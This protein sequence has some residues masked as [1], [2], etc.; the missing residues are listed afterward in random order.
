MKPI[1]YNKF[2]W[3]D[4]EETDTVSASSIL[5]LLPDA[6]VPI[7]RRHFALSPLLADDVTYKIN[8]VL[9]H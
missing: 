4:K 6:P 7:S 3:P 9:S 5:T 1:G 8:S 2:I